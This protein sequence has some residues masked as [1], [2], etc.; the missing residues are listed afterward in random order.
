MNAERYTLD[1]NILF[2]ALSQ[3]A[4]LKHEVACQLW[5]SA[6][7]HD[8]VLT[9]QA[10]GETYNAFSRKAGGR[11]EDAQQALSDLITLVP[12]VCANEDDLRIA[13][14]L[15]KERPVQFWDAMLWTTARRNGCR[16]I[17]TE[18]FQ[19]HVE[20]DGV[21]YVNPFKVAPTEL[22]QYL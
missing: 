5:K 7:H 18:D 10:V 20:W 11:M 14:Q 3:D 19:D 12:V 21:R 16:V 9:L 2:Y 8:C 17:L 1:A 15:R 4:G 13:M 22:W 6:V